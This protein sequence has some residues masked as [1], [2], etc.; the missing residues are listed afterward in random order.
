MPALMKLIGLN[1]KTSGQERGPGG[2]TCLVS[3][4]QVAESKK[5]LE[6]AAWPLPPFDPCLLIRMEPEKGSQGTLRGWVR[7]DGKR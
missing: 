7:P 5:N 2:T 1:S 3:D 4:I 6:I